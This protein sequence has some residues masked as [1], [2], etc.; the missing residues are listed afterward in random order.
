MTTDAAA[1][2]LAFALGLL[3]GIVF[4]AG[5]WWTIRRALHVRRPHLLLCNSFILR[6]AVVLLTLYFGALDELSHT[7]VFLTGFLL[8]KYGALHRL[9]PAAAQ[10]RPS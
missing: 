5:L 3:S 7:F 10:R 1:I 2:A 6:S 4:F 8:A 9:P